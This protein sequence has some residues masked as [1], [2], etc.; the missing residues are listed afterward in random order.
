MILSTYTYQPVQF[1]LTV[2]IITFLLGGIAFYYNNMKKTQF[3]FML[4]G[5]FAPF[6]IT[7]FMI[8]GSQN[9]ELIQDFYNRFELSRIQPNFLPVIV[10]LMPCVLF[11]ATTLSLLFGQSVN[12]FHFSNAFTTINMQSL[13][14]L[15]IPFVASIVEEL[16]WRGYGVDSLRSKYDLF[17]TTI[18]FALLWALWH[19]PGFFLRGT[20]FHALLRMNNIYVVNFFVSIIPATILLNWVYYKNDRSIISGILLHF[21][22]NFCATALQT[23]QFTKVI[24][25]ILLLIISVIVIVKDK[26]LFFT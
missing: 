19:V 6:I 17:T 21:M 9:Q 2:F 16:G 3:F 10:L 12:Q 24:I 7:L 20:Y 14:S 13:F 18:I 11:L 23:K 25:T 8:Y 4:C 26:I 1:F 5:I 15:L 22:F